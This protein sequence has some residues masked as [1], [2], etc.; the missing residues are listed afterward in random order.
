M[1]TVRLAR[2]LSNQWGTVIDNLLYQAALPGPYAWRWGNG[3]K[4][5]ITLDADGR[6]QKIESPGVQSLAFGYTA[7]DLVQ[8][9]TDGIDPSLNSS[10]GW[11]GSGRLTSVS[12]SNGDNQSIAYD[13]AGNRTN[14]NG[15]SYQY[16]ASGR[17]WL[18]QVSSRAYSW[19][20]WKV[21]IRCRTVCRRGP[22]RL[23]VFG[24]I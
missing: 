16:G 15:T 1:A 18:T 23:T 7:N 13:T 10:Y 8:G 12:R 11:D 4:R 5:G 2:I 6:P 24:G 3:D 21:W 20:G 19:D 14:H 22:L 9:V 17:D